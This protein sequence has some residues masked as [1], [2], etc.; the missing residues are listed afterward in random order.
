MVSKVTSTF[1]YVLLIE[2][3][4]LGGIAALVTACLSSNPVIMLPFGVVWLTGQFVAPWQT[5]IKNNT[6]IE[7]ER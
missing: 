1:S 2:L 7:S 3:L 6:H 4:V 5:L